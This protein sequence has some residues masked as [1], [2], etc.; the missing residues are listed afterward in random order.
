MFINAKIQKKRD[1]ETSASMVFEKFGIRFIALFITSLESHFST[2]F[3]D[4]GM[5]QATH[6]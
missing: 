5:L 3:K 6:Y 2:K 1:S 4:S